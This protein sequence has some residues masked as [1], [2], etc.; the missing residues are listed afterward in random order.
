MREDSTG[1]KLMGIQQRLQIGLLTVSDFDFGVKSS[2]IT[3][4]VCKLFSQ[5]KLDL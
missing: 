5:M 3:G 1:L 4:F 2:M